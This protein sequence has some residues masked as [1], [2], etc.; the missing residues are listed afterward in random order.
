V[1]AYA[2]T[3]LHGYMAE[4]YE[5]V[6]ARALTKA[7]IDADANSMRLKS[8]FLEDFSPLDAPDIAY[9]ASRDR[10]N[11]SSLERQKTGRPIPEH[12]RAGLPFTY[13]DQQA[14]STSSSAGAK[15]T[16]SDARRVNQCDLDAPR[17]SGPKSSALPTL[18][19]CLKDLTPS[20]SE[21]PSADPGLSSDINNL[22]GKQASYT[23]KPSLVDEQSSSIADISAP[24]LSDSDSLLTDT[25]E[26]RIFV[27][28]GD[29][30]VQH[31]NQIAST[32]T[33][34]ISSASYLSAQSDIFHSSPE[35]SERSFRVHQ[36]EIL[37]QPQAYTALSSDSVANMSPPEPPYESK[38]AKKAQK[39]ARKRERKAELK[40]LDNEQET[41][42]I[43]SKTDD[44]N[45]LS[46]PKVTAAT[47][48]QDRSLDTD[49]ERR[50]ESESVTTTAAVVREYPRVHQAS[51]QDSPMAHSSQISNILSEHYDLSTDLRR[52]SASKEKGK[53]RLEVLENLVDPE[54]PSTSHPQDL[55]AAVSA[56]PLV[57]TAEHQDL[58]TE[59]PLPSG[60]SKGSRKERERNEPTENIPVDIGH[61]G[62]HFSGIIDLESQ[63]SHL[64]SQEQHLARLDHPQLPTITAPDTGLRPP[65]TKEKGRGHVNEPERTTLSS[66]PQHAANTTRTGLPS[67]PPI[68]QKHQA[69]ES[70]RLADASKSTIVIPIPA[71][72]QSS[73]S[74]PQHSLT[75]QVQKRDNKSETTPFLVPT[76]AE[77]TEF[78]QQHQG[79]IADFAVEDDEDD[80]IAVVRDAIA[81]A[82]KE[83]KVI[84]RRS[85]SDPTIDFSPQ[86]FAHSKK[87]KAKKKNEARKKKKE[88]EKLTKDATSGPLAKQSEAIQ[89]ATTSQTGATFQAGQSFRTT[90]YDV[91]S[92]TSES[93]STETIIRTPSSSSA[94]VISE[95]SSSATIVPRDRPRGIFTSP[96]NQ[97]LEQFVTDTLNKEPYPYTPWATY[98]NFDYVPPGD[99]PMKYLMTQPETYW[100]M[101]PET[102]FPKEG[103]QNFRIRYQA[104]SAS[105]CIMPGFS[106]HD[107]KSQPYIIYDK[108]MNNVKI[109]PHTVP[110][111]DLRMDVNHPDWLPTR[112]LC[113][114]QAM[115]LAGYE[116]ARH[117]RLNAPC[118]LKSCGKIIEDF[119]KITVICQACGPKTLIRYCRYEHQVADLHLHWQNE[120]GVSLRAPFTTPLFAN[121]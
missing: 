6:F 46:G 86:T 5:Y 2:N 75:I 43:A 72:G 115:E 99:S 16:A 114:H 112:K 11:V 15:L 69:T 88:A 78:L 7:R 119:E 40:R 9:L 31:L 1:Q 93:S 96:E 33:S 21:R 49:K 41:A 65:S 38:D 28:T 103:E 50:D 66:R 105:A 108:V 90:T 97:E 45:E 12:E 59:L 64:T 80:D 118:A 94:S 44:N 34:S 71:K 29:F 42:T 22:C 48:A 101:S 70:S 14:L 83:H 47:T 35:P 62:G 91:E 77:I 79:L 82:I 39:K 24:T 23:I 57:T 120:C 102:W 27:N 81:K 76:T 95:T 26:R 121:I 106:I 113:E 37:Q 20:P 67:A 55:E 58:A 92:T 56:Q 17:S 100:V 36:E 89:V 109:W 84:H 19:D 110:L 87:S 51:T 98:L 53:Q 54:S 52:P 68:H 25:I 18:S 117:D 32:S 10:F 13:G 61:K 4:G 73:S 107:N 74:R 116:T 111:E 63:H 3:V 8:M 85:R 30:A 104:M 60:T